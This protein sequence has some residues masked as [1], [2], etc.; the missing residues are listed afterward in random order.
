MRLWKFPKVCRNRHKRSN[1]CERFG[2][3]TDIPDGSRGLENPT[4]R[5]GESHSK[6]SLERILLTR[7]F[8]ISESIQACLENK[9]VS[10]TNGDD[11]SGN[12]LP[13]P[14]AGGA[15]GGWKGLLNWNFM[16]L[17]VKMCYRLESSVV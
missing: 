2:F 1:D 3:G 7:F 15:G 13:D 16:K 5:K 12:I 8:R 14:K 17:I 4:S 9:K 10:N 6:I 11:S